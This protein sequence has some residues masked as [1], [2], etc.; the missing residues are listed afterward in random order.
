MSHSQYQQEPVAIVGLACRLPGENTSPQKLWDFLER[1]GIAS[2]DVPSSRF[3]ASAH[4]DGSMKRRTMRPKGGMFL[5]SMDPADFD[6]SFFEI[7]STE[8]I[9]MDPNQRQ[10]LE[11]VF[12]ALENA[13]IT[14][15]ALNGAPVACFTG[16]YASGTLI[17]GVT[18]QLQSS[19]EPDYDT[20]SNRDPEDRPANIAIGIGRA[21]LAN[22]LSH[23]LNIKGPS[24]TIDTAC[25]GSL[26]GLDVACRYLH[27][28]EI[29]A[30]IIATSNLYLNPEHVSKSFPQKSSRFCCIS[31]LF[32][33]GSWKC[34]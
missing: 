1:G 6:A 8:A 20:M 23:F 32:H 14:L 28:R 12:E 17:L 24:M 16:S 33:S 18:R 3:N 4:Y 27:T 9:S 30:A 13:G 22:R 11:V 7:S 29:N 10:M 19:P 5:E 31:N 34:G 2:N 25:S 26:I 15:E 21:I